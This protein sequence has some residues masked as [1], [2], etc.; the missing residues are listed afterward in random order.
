MLMQTITY[1][2]YLFF[3]PSLYRVFFALI[4]L[5]VYSRLNQSLPVYIMSKVKIISSAA[6]LCASILFSHSS[7]ACTLNTDCSPGST[8]I[9]NGGLYGYCMGGIN[10]GNKF[11]RN[12]ATDLGGGAGW[13]CNFNTQCS[14]GYACVKSQGIKGVC[15]KR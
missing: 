11:D 6:L 12:P 2:K 7:Y 5:G 13:T 9:K 3:I 4:L 14:P 10:P 15:L 1:F 8:C